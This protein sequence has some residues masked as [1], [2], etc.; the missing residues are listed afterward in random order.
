MWRKSNADSLWPFFV[1]ATLKAVFS[2]VQLLSRVWLFTTP[3]TA[4]VQASQT[5]SSPELYP[6]SCPLHQWCHPAISSSDALFFLLPLIFPS[7]RDFSNE[8]SVHIRWLKYWSFSFTISPSSEYSGLISL[9]IDWFDLLAVHGTFRSL[10]QH[11]NWKASIL[12]HSA[13]FKVQ[14]SQP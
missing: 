3:W 2:S 7:I 8:L 11:H 10:P 5:S 14:L 6:S 12:W 13:F 4:A 1:T 9:K